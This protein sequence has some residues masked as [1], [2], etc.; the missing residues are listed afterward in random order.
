M[1]VGVLSFTKPRHEIFFINNSGMSIP[2]ILLPYASSNNLSNE[3][4]FGYFSKILK[5]GK[6]ACQR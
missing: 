1:T 6:C 5:K 2:E 3:K 4:S